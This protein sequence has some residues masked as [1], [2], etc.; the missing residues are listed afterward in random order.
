M[1]AFLSRHYN[2]RN[3]KEDITTGG[4]WLKK[5]YSATEFA[6]DLSALWNTKL[7]TADR[8][9]ELLGER[10]FLWILLT[11]SFLPDYLVPTGSSG[12]GVLFAYYQSTHTMPLSLNIAA[13]DSNRK[14][15]DIKEQWRLLGLSSS[16]VAWLD[17]K[18]KA[19]I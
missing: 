8:L 12:L 7:S 15:I 4:L 10:S 9:K 13:R 5:T 1:D 18:W 2:I 6:L 14:I 17:R 3:V 16:V 19:I 11:Y